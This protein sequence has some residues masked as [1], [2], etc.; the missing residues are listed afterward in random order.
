MLSL[1]IYR[2]SACRVAQNLE[3]YKSQSMHANETVTALNVIIAVFRA[4]ASDITWLI[5]HGPVFRVSFSSGLDHG[6]DAFLFIVFVCLVPW[7]R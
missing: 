2:H 3:F 5:S 7:H 6:M 1:N 4:C